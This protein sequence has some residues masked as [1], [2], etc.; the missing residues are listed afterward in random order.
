MKINRKQL[1]KLISSEIKKNILEGK[2]PGGPSNNVQDLS[3]FDQKMLEHIVELLNRMQNAEE[4]IESASENESDLA[5][6]VIKR[7]EVIERFLEDKFPTEFFG[8][9]KNFA[10]PGEE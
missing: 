1:Q 9:G 5:N 4:R 8:G 6:D 10:I 7:I 3:P 2:L